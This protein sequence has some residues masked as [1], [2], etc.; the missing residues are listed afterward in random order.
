LRLWSLHPKYLDAKGLV[1]CWRE[2]LL[3]KHVLQGKTKGYKHHPQLVR[4]IK[5]R[6]P[7]AG[8]NGY[9][10][11]LYDEAVQRKYNFDRSKFNPVSTPAKLRV[12]NGQVSYEFEHLLKKLKKRNRKKY[13][14]LKDVKR[15]QTHPLFNVINGEIEE[16]EIV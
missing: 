15:I 3:A 6:H 8:I 5:S 12:T 9:L 16:W 1:A 11:A 7:L 13:N 14:D 4:F 10:Q 2:A